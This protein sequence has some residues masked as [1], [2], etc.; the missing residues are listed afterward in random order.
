V[1]LPLERLDGDLG[2]RAELAVQRD[3]VAVMAQALLDREDGLAVGAEVHLPGEAG[4]DDD[5]RPRAVGTGLVGA[6]TLTVG[7]GFGTTGLAVCET[8]KK[9]DTD[10]ARAVATAAILDLVHFRPLRASVSACTI[11]M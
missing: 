2:L 3:R 9:T 10:T 1:V 7:T 8:P 6:G 11:F 5:S 4:D